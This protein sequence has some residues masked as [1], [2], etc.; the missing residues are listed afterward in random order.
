MEEISKELAQILYQSAIVVLK[1]DK[2]LIARVDYLGTI[3]ILRVNR[4]GEATLREE[5]GDL[6]SK[7]LDDIERAAEAGWKKI[8]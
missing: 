1:K 6:P 4:K 3:S 8:K 7:L 2:Q 5:N